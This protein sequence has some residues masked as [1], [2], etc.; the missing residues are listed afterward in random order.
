MAPE[1]LS[2]ILSATCS[3]VTLKQCLS[4]HPYLCRLAYATSGEPMLQ[5]Y[6]GAA[7]VR[8]YTVGSAVPPLR[9]HLRCADLQPLR[10]HLPS[11]RPGGGCQCRGKSIPSLT[12]VSSGRRQNDDGKALKMEMGTRR[13]HWAAMWL[14][15]STCPDFQV[16]LFSLGHV[17]ECAC[18][19]IDY[20]SGRRLPYKAIPA[21]AEYGKETLYLL[22][23]TA[24]LLQMLSQ[25]EE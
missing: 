14:G 24:E 7:A 21:R 3:N 6:G 18:H 8:A 22:H 2:L 23:R 5:L 20:T 13:G 10:I 16:F 25:A 17:C 1:L 11:S 15:C 19:D 9:A 4:Q 12:E